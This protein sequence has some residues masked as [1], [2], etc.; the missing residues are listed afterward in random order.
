SPQF[1]DG[2]PTGN[3]GSVNGGSANYVGVCYDT[4]NENDTQLVVSLTSAWYCDGQSPSLQ[5]LESL[6]LTESTVGTCAAGRDLALPVD[7]EI[8]QIVQSAIGYVDIKATVGVTTIALS[9]KQAEC[10]E[11]FITAGTSTLPAV[12][13]GVALTRQTA[14]AA[15]Q[16]VSFETFDDP[17]GA[18]VDPHTVLGQYFASNTVDTDFANSYYSAFAGTQTAIRVP[19]FTYSDVEYGMPAYMAKVTSKGTGAVSGQRCTADSSFTSALLTITYPY[20]GGTPLQ[21][22]SWAEQ[23]GTQSTLHIYYSSD[24][25]WS[26]NHIN[27][28]RLAKTFT[29]VINRACQAYHDQ[30]RLTYA[31]N[32]PSNPTAAPKAINCTGVMGQ[33]SWTYTSGDPVDLSQAYCQP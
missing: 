18:P 22:T 20:W 17:N 7:F 1:R 31:L 11:G 3:S 32:D 15:M 9:G 12:I 13:S 2:P 26:V 6:P 28:T 33:T 24:H 29:G 19:L 21:L 5:L 14:N 8:T 4:G 10:D 30:T 25:D 27:P 23:S 16:F